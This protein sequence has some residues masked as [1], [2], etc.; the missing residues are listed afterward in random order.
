M[1]PTALRPEFGG[2]DNAPRY[3]PAHR[4]YMG[5]AFQVQ[6]QSGRSSS[7]SRSRSG[8]PL[9][10]YWQ[11]LLTPLLMSH[12]SHLERSGTKVRNVINLLV[13]DFY[14]SAIDWTEISGRWPVLHQRFE[15]A[16]GREALDNVGVWLQ[17]VVTQP[18][19]LRTL[20]PDTFYE[21]PRFAERDRVRFEPHRGAR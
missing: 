8:C 16:S 18:A 7:P 21:D 19:V 17:K 2:I 15:K 12:L 11:E 6:A 14:S 5:R 10:S 20:Q 9:Q 3:L 13:E 4:R 1:P